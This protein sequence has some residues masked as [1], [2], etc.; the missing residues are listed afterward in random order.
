MS[1]PSKNLVFVHDWLVTMRGGE[2][3]L[4]T[5]HGL[6]PDAPIYTLLAQPNLFLNGLRRADIRTSFLQHLPSAQ[7]FHRWLLP[8]YP[9]AVSRWNLGQADVIVSI[10][11]SVAKGARKAPGAFHLCYCLSPMRYVW[12]NPELYFSQ[13]PSWLGKER[14]IRQLK[15]W[16]LETNKD[17]DKFIAISATIQKRIERC[18]GRPSEIIYP[19]VDCQRFERRSRNPENLYLIVS[20]LVPYKRV[21]LAIE[22]CRQLKRSLVIVGDGPCRSALQQQAGKDVQ[23]LGWCPPDVIEELYSRAK[24]LLYPQEEDF[25]IAVVEAQSSGCPVIA[26]QAG[27]ALETVVDKLTGHFFPTQTSEALAQA[28]LEAEAMDF[29]LPVLRQQARRFDRRIFDQK[30]KQLLEEILRRGRGS[31]AG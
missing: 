15:E 13:I 28:M 3:V 17:I 8:V 24:A 23:F 18:Y 11:H 19:P 29:D 7:R 27:G 9:W 26:Y 1:T 31:D 6:W 5:L 4:E 30:F 2:K 16:D 21:E 20:A 25:G 12:E 22:A 14:F 10:S